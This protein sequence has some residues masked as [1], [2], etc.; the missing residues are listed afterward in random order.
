MS[1][2]SL[3]RRGFL[4]CDGSEPYGGVLAVLSRIFLGLVFLGCS[5]VLATEEINGRGVLLV[6]KKSTGRTFDVLAACTEESTGLRFV[7]FSTKTAEST[8]RRVVVLSTEE[9][10]GRGVDVLA[11]ERRTIVLTA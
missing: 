3:V 5:L 2:N 9:S 11:A 10:A 7:A 4:I 1:E 6:T 8:G